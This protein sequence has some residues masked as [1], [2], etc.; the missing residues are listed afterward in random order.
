[1]GDCGEENTAR[2]TPEEATAPALPLREPRPPNTAVLFRQL[3]E[4]PH[5]PASREAAVYA[6]DAV[7]AFA[8]DEIPALDMLA[9]LAPLDNLAAAL[10]NLDD[11]GH[12]PLLR[13]VARSGRAPADGMMIRLKALAAITIDR[14]CAIDD[15]SEPLTQRRQRAYGE[16]ADVLARRGIMPQ[17]AGA[18]DKRG[19]GAI[20][21][22][23]IRG[24]YDEVMQV[25]KSSPLRRQY[26]KLK[27]NSRWSR[28]QMEATGALMR[29]AYGDLHDAAAHPA[30]WRAACL[31]FFRVGLR[32]FST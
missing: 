31:S 15:P 9:L 14:L 19:I 17:R 6:L 26:E 29:E 4:N 22:R 20:T 8:R 30:R 1:M 10:R 13:P 21:A 23:T 5:V 11:G 2:A 18:K 7:M 25:A 3:Q 28:A 16:I 27:E 12:P 32:E 24:W